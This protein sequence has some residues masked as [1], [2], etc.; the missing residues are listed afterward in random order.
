VT[1]GT[2]PDLRP[3][4]DPAP[5]VVARYP[6]GWWPERADGRFLAAVAE[7]AETTVVV[8]EEQLAEL[9]APETVERGWQ[10]ITFPG[11]LPWELIGFLADIATRL[12]EARI[13]FTSVSGFSTDHVL[14]RS[15]QAELAL[16]VLRGE[17]VPE[18]RADVINP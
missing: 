4:L 11:P 3:V 17:P 15:A 1:D 5:L 2:R 8:A 10:R 6:S 14:V 12:A 16:S 7:P 9:P 18:L 13:P